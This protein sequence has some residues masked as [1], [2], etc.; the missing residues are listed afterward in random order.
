MQKEAVIVAP[1]AA[2]PKITAK[3]A[4]YPHRL[5][6]KMPSETPY[7]A[8]RAK[9]SCPTADCNALSRPR[10]TLKTDNKSA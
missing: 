3:P 5:F 9:K 7:A 2:V 6:R 4:M 8:I 10:I 1:A